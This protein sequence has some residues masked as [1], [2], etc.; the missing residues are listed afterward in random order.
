MKKL[1]SA[2]LLCCTLV[3]YSQQG[4]KPIDQLSQKMID[5]FEKQDSGSNLFRNIGISAL[6]AFDPPTAAFL[7]AWKEQEQLHPEMPMSSMIYRLTDTV[8][9]RLS[10]YLL[11]KTSSENVKYTDILQ[12]YQSGICPCI[13]SK[14]SGEEPWKHYVKALNKCDDSLRNDQKY[15]K[16]FTDLVTKV[17]SPE[18]SRLGYLM[19]R[20]VFLRCPALKNAGFD[21]AQKLVADHQDELVYTLGEY[22]FRWPAYYYDR[23]QVDSLSGLFPTYKKFEQ[24]LKSAVLM[25]TVPYLVS[26]GP[27]PYSDKQG[28]KLLTFYSVQWGGIAIRGQLL[29]TYSRSLPVVITGYAFTPASKV[30]NTEQ[31]KKKI[32]KDNL[33]QLLRMPLPDDDF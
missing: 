18:R 12:V 14:L 30:K 1:F 19:E 13:T 6:T 5:A 32:E 20:F 31:L 17:P 25:D 24:D 7:G 4:N 26:E 10:I 21:Y 16:R 9:N 29:C 11:N 3:V 23:K 33:Q 28:S 15:W 27:I 2:L 22:L 8:F